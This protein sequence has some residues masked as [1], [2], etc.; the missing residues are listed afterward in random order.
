M[1]RVAISLD[2]ETPF[3]ELSMSP[4]MRTASATSREV[5]AHLTAMGGRKAVMSKVLPDSEMSCWK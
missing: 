2:S 4:V 5:V 3:L 1:R